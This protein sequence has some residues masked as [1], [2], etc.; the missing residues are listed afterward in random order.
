MPQAKTQPPSKTATRQFES[1][2]AGMVRAMGSQYKNQTLKELGKGDVEK[3]A[4][5]KSGNYAAVWLALAAKVER[6]LAK[7][8]SN[9]KLEQAVK[10]HLD[11]QDKQ[12]RAAFYAAVERATGVDS[13]TLLATDT[14]SESRAAL[15]LESTQ[16]LKKM[17]DDTLE[18]WTANTLRQMTE[19]KGIGEIMQQFDGMVE[20]RRNHAKFVARTQINSFNGL[21]TKIRG[22]NLGIERAIWRTAKDERVRPCHKARDGKEYLLSEGLY[23]SCDGKTLHPGTDYQCFAGHL[24]LDNTSFC[25]KVFRRWFVGDMAHITFG[26]GS[27]LSATVN[28]PILTD[29]GFKAAGLIDSS[30]NVVRT[31][32]KGFNG[33]EVNSD[34]EIPTFEQIFRAFELLGVEISVSPSVAGDFHGDISNGDIDI[35]RVDSLLVDEINPSIREKFAKLNLSDSDK[36]VVLS[37]LTCLSDR[38]LSGFRLKSPSASDM[39][40]LD[41]VRS[42]FL[43]HLT[44]LESFGFALGSWFDPSIKEALPD[45]AAA[46]FEMFSDCIFAFSVLVHGNNI[47]DRQIDAW[48]RS[49]PRSFKPALAKFNREGCRGDIEN[50]SGILNKHTVGYK[51]DSP[52]NV[53]VRHFSGH[54]YNLETSS[55][56]YNVC[57]STVSNCRCTA[58]LV[59][60]D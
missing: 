48:H 51:L 27:V 18:E 47:F 43:A 45:N 17:R 2:V 20:K 26:D 50:T 11:K 30:D 15:I 28:H 12:S 25:K 21:M 14:T 16:W 1:M 39:R 49:D 32:N 9:D 24:Q 53:S 36:M 41:L 23:S 35:I 54:V 40:I 33:V 37:L 4:D 10:Q 3:F 58:E 44:P 55:N 57:A 38:S 42:S 8:F 34:Y 5:A 46:G 7:R 13:K 31:I 56:D 59:L 22:Q 6:K 19:G 60:D 29:R 52:I